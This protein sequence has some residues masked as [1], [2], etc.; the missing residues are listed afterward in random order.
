[1]SKHCH[2]EKGRVGIVEARELQRDPDAGKQGKLMEIVPVLV[3]ERDVGGN[4][5]TLSR[6]FPA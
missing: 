5:V 2:T 6:L 1:M 3:T 4:I